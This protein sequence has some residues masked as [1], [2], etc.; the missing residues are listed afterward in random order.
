MGMLINILVVFLAV[1]F[2]K[3][4]VFNEYYYIRQEKLSELRLE[5]LE[6]SSTLEKKMRDSEL[7]L[8]SYEHDV[9]FKVMHN[10]AILTGYVS[11]WHMLRMFLDPFYRVKVRKIQNHI[12]RDAESIRDLEVKEL[13]QK[14]QQVFCHVFCIRHPVIFM[15]VLLRICFK[16]W[17]V[18]M[19][20]A[21]EKASQSSVCQEDILSFQAAARV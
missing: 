1:A 12:Q 16:H 15:F 8:G 6:I 7:C 3:R 4:F 10:D 5:L 20:L 13:F 11:Y 17:R 9:L 2:L 18:V 19:T 14:H 21:K